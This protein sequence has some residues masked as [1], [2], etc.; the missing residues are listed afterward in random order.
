[1]FEIVQVF[2]M[3]VSS[4]HWFLPSAHSKFMTENSMI[5]RRALCV[6]N[7]SHLT[8]WTWL[9]LCLLL[10][11]QLYMYKFQYSALQCSCSSNASQTYLWFLVEK[12]NEKQGDR[13]RFFL[14][15]A[16]TAGQES[17]RQVF[18][19]TLLQQ[20]L[21][22]FL[23]QPHVFTLTLGLLPQ[24]AKNDCSQQL[25]FVSK[26]PLVTS[27]EYFFYFICPTVLPKIFLIVS[28]KTLSQLETYYC[29]RV[30]ARQHTILVN[31]GK[32]P[33]FCWI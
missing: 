22:Q 12:L 28:H 20:Q 7:S 32:N 31:K 10:E 11:I 27:L 2:Q 24:V 18:T 17:D 5:Y 9:S 29:W 21:N 1:M 4:T 25:D 26:N 19:E 16:D 15:K 8:A 6:Q 33:K 14:S 23:V 30:L 3:K 13:I